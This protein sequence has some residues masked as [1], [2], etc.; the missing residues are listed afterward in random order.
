MDDDRHHAKLVT[1]RNDDD[2]S[3]G[4]RDWIIG[5]VIAA[6]ALLAIVAVTGTGSNSITTA[7][8]QMPPARETTGSASPSEPA[9]ATPR[10]TR[11]P[12]RDR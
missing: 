1:Y 10:N 2:D 11:P 5:G 7:S 9:L 8:N 6:V 4:I 3:I 12:L